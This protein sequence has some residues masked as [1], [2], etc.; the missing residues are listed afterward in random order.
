MSDECSKI[1]IKRALL[2]KNYTHTHT[3][4]F[5]VY[6]GLSIGVMVFMLYKLYVLLPY[7]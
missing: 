2:F 6:V 1:K 4:V 7:T 5:M 3:L